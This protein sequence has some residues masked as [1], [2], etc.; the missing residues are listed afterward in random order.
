MKRKENKV[1]YFGLTIHLS[2]VHFK[3][4]NFFFIEEYHEYYCLQIDER[5]GDILAFV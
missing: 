2:T 3:N 5:A 1:I 4:Q